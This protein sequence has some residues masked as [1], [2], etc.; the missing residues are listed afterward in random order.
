LK[1]GTSS[2][3]DATWA[4][5]TVAPAYLCARYR[6]ARISA[7]STGT[8]SPLTAASGGG[9]VETDALAPVGDYASAAVGRE[10]VLEYFSREAGTPVVILRLNYAVETRYGVL[11]DIALKVWNGESVDLSMGFLNCIWQGDANEAAIRAL[12]HAASPPLALNLT[13]REVLAVRDIATRL[14][15]LLGRTPRF[16]GVE[17]PTA[18]LSNSSRACALLGPPSTPI[19]RVLGGTA[20]RGSRR[21]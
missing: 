7:V 12:A 15:R 13:G 3:P 4:T 9:A 5:N 17:S 16:S 14:G 6:G 19:D 11:H 20:P 10:R 8:V 21:G 2:R 1:F 18:L